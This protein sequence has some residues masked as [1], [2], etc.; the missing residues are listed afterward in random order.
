MPY[1]GVATP[2]TFLPGGQAFAT[3]HQRSFHLGLK[4]TAQSLTQA[5]GTTIIMFILSCAS[6][7]EP[8][9]LQYQLLLEL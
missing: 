4:Q 7:L 3:R 1:L 6:N 2:L 9:I 5:S 8:V